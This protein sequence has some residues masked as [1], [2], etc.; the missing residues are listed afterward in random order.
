MRPAS[1]QL[2]S[3]H[4]SPTPARTSPTPSRAS[5][6]CT[7][8]SRLGKAGRLRFDDP[9]ANMDTFMLLVTSFGHTHELWLRHGYTSQQCQYLQSLMFTAANEQ[10]WIR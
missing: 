5:H 6:P 2:V 1:L 9:N 3:S 10:V 8:V 7:A 4:L